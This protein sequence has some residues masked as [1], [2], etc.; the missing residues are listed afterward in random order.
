MTLLDV[1]LLIRRP[2]VTLNTGQASVG[3]AG[4]LV[5]LTLP[6]VA[7]WPMQMVNVVI[8]D[9]IAPVKAPCKRESYVYVL[10]SL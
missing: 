1:I 8:V 2:D 9:K 4:S 6:S 10:Y 5:F 3:P 7:I